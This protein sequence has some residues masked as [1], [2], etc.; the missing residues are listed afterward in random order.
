MLNTKVLNFHITEVNDGVRRR[1]KVNGA[2]YQDNLFAQKLLHAEHILDIPW[3]A[4]VFRQDI[5]P[6]HQACDTVAFLGR[7]ALDFIP[8]TLWPPNS[9]DLNPNDY[10]ICRK[11]FPDPA[12]IANVDELKTPLIDEWERFDQSI[13]H[14]AIYQWR[15]RLS[16]CVRVSRTHFEH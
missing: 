12:R 15:R 14:V 3:W 7:K 13:L 10:S 1:V 11:K 8:P 2:Y 16:A 4:F 6:A 5:A 9:P